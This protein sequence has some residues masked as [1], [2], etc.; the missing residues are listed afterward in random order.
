MVWPRLK[1][2]WFSKDDPRTK[3]KER[4][5]E[6]DRRRGGKNNIKESIVMDFANSTRAAEKQEMAE[7]DCCEVICGTPTTCQGYGIA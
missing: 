6:V 7:R 3:L 5:E 1:V 4:E 2:F